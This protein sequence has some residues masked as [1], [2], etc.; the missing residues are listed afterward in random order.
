MSKFFKNPLSL[1][2]LMLSASSLPVM[3]D[4]P[5]AV[6]APIA[7]VQVHQVMVK[8]QS[9]FYREAGKTSSPTIVLLHG[10]PSSSHMFRDLIPRLA[11]RFHVIAPDYIGFG[12]SSAPA[13]DS[14]AYTFDN[15]AAHVQG[16]LDQLGVHKA[17]YYMQDY[18]GPVGMR[19]AT[20]HPERVNGLVI[21]NANAYMEGVGKPVADVFLPLW[22]ERNASTEAAARGFLKPETTR[23]QYTAGARDPEKLNPD[24]WVLDQ[25]LLDRPGNDAIQLELF[26][27]YRSNVPLFDVWQAYFR[28]HQ[29]RTLI[30]WGEGDPFFVAAGAHA[31]KKDLPDAR[32]LWLKGGH[33]ALEEN[34]DL[35]AREIKHSFR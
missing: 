15:L 3:A 13:A 29:P 11:D 2:A 10:F 12:H 18:G 7:Q 25:A 23:L 32:L 16:L 21:Q 1:L 20:A 19:L 17:I 9:V 24:A 28:R 33:F 22:K 26:V 6:E 14:F 34:V 27:D 4:T 5:H 8:G 35:V 31:Y 30:L